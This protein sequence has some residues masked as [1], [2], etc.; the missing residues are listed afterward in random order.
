MSGAVTILQGDVRDVLATL[1]DAS[2]DCIVTDP[3]YGETSLAWDR[4]P[5]GWPG[6]LRRVLKSS[7]S[8]WE[9]ITV[10]PKGGAAPRNP[11]TIARNHVSER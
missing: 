6:L 10:L 3:P 5:E 4:W 7:G 8:M 2:F 11:T 9:V 1:P